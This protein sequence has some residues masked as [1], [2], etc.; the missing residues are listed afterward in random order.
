MTTALFRSAKEGEWPQKCFHDQVCTKELE[1]FHSFLTE[2]W[3]LI[4][5]D[6]FVYAQYLDDQLMDFDKIL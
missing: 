2:L 1:M 4:Y 6:I 5:I 3:P